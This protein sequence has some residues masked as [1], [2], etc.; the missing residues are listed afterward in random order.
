M[1]NEVTDYVNQMKNSGAATG[2]SPG[3]YA[4]AKAAGSSCNYPGNDENVATVDRAF[5]TCLIQRAVLAG[6]VGVIR[7]ARMLGMCPGLSLVRP[8]GRL[9]RRM[10]DVRGVPRAGVGRCGLWRR[11]AH[12]SG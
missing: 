3:R 6:V 12:D 11:D 9:M 2:G 10:F 7:T 1:S 4:D 8:V 5:L